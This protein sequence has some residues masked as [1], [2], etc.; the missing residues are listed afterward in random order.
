MK[1]MY[2]IK[3]DEKI[4]KSSITTLSS[5]LADIKVKQTCTDVHRIYL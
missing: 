5:V 1:S 2:K 4:L 3:I